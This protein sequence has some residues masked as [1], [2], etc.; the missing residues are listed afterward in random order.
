MALVLSLSDVC[1]KLTSEWSE[2]VRV[3]AST[4]EG[5]PAVGCH[6]D[7]AM[8]LDDGVLRFIEHK[9]GHRRRL[10]LVFDLGQILEVGC[11]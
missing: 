11:L 7:K 5:T 2:A 3:H 10:L 8:A 6:V 9:T 1:K 4:A